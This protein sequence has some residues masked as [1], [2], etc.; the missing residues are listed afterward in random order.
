MILVGFTP[1]CAVFS[2]VPETS[3]NPNV[4]AFMLPMLISMFWSA[5][6]PTW[7]FLFLKEPSSKFCLLNWVVEEILSNSVVKASNSSLIA[8]RSIDSFVSL[9][10]CTANSFIL[11]KIE[12]ASF[13]APSA[14]WIKETPSWAFVD[15]RFSPRTW[16]LI[17]SEIFNPAASSPARLI[18]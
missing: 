6:A 15:A 11:C 16:L 12:W 3:F 9:A 4:L 10:P 8:S 17:F 1:S 14:V 18:L 13:K 2:I 5:L 7:S